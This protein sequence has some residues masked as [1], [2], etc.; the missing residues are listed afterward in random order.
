MLP[1]FRVQRRKSVLLVL[2]VL[3]MFVGG[4]GDR[5]EVQDNPSTGEPPNEAA[6]AGGTSSGGDDPD[7]GTTETMPGSGGAHAGPVDEEFC[8]EEDAFCVINWLGR[9]DEDGFADGAPAQVRLSAARGI[10]LSEGRAYLTHQHAVFSIDLETGESELLAG[11]QKPGKVDGPGETARF[12]TPTGLALVDDQLYVTDTLN[13]RVVVIDLRTRVVSTFLSTLVSGPVGL[14]VRDGP[15]S[16]NQYLMIADAVLHI[17]LQVDL[18]HSPPTPGVLIGELGIAGSNTVRLNEPFGLAVIGETLYVSERGNHMIRS[19]DLSRPPPLS[20]RPVWGTGSPG[21]VEAESTAAQLDSPQGLWARDD[22][23]YVVDSGNRVL[24][25]GVPGAA[26]STIAGMPHEE[27]SDQGPGAV[28][29]FFVPMGLASSDRYLYVTDGA[30]L[31]RVR[32]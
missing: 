9:D 14:L 11:S 21:Y 24:R 1:D 18:T 25:R 2:F 23:L 32:L 8:S 10:A 13:R 7:T 12:N 26:L 20:L 4:C 6:A 27:G 16:A 30:L 28:A 29:T 17:V 15:S 22:R 31:R 3:S 5:F 19:A